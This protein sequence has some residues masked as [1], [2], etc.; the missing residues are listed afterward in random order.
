M[1][2]DVQIGF[3]RGQLLEADSIR[4][5][6]LVWQREST[7]DLANLRHG[8]ADELVLVLHHPDRVLNSAEW[9]MW[10]RPARSAG[11]VKVDDKRKEDLLLFHHVVGHFR[12][13]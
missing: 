5:A 8:I 7:R 10:N 9:W 4:R 13:D 11:L 12:G 2:V 1:N 6:R 3:E